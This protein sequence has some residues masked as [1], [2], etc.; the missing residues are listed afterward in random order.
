MVAEAVPAEVPAAPAPIEVVAAV[1]PVEVVAEAV[2]AEVPAAPAPVE[3]VAAVPPVEVVA[4]VIPAEVHAA[5]VPVEVV[6]A[7]PPV[8]SIAP[9]QAESVEPVEISEK[10]E[11]P[12]A[13]EALPLAGKVWGPKNWSGRENSI[14]APFGVNLNTARPADLEAIPGI[15]PARAMEIIQYRETNGPFKNIY[16]LAK[17]PGVGHNQFKQMT[18]LSLS[19]GRNRYDTLI[20]LLKI[21]KDSRLTMSAIMEAIT[22]RIDAEDCVI[23]S[24]DGFLLTR[25]ASMNDPVRIARYA[26]I[27]SQ[28]FRRTGKYL[29]NLTG[30][31]V[32]C[33]QLPAATP[34]LLLFASDSFYFVFSHQKNV[35]S[36]RNI[37]IGYN[38]VIELNWL[39]AKRAIVRDL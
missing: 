8:L 14:T 34:V 2:P 30:S 26:A 27:S 13:R 3:V 15:G 4:E 23:S 21:E 24:T 5:T 11:Q 10:A 1:P 35:F 7:V 31:S 22:K 20:K 39:F 17:L 29:R 38:I 28:L 36:A 32:D 12:E 18:G 33:I 19:T 16:E 6:A 37:R 9:E 25:T